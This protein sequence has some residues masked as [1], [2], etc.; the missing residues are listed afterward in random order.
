MRRDLESVHFAVDAPPDNL[1]EL[2]EA[3]EQFSDEHPE[4]SGLVKLRFF[5]GLS[6]EEAHAVGVSRNVKK[7][8]IP[9]SPLEFLTVRRA[10]SYDIA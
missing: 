10:A 2:N 6:L 3:L 1:L 4:K 8:R 7:K 5:A 9:S